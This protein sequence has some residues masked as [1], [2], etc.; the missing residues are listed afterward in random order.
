MKCPTCGHVSGPRRLEYL[1]PEQ[2]KQR[3]AARVLKD[4][5][6][7]SNYPDI[8][9]GLSKDQAWAWAALE[10]LDR[11]SKLYMPK[12]LPWEKGNG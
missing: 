12:R 8:L 5:Q 1:T 6:H 4:N 3:W 11:K 2:R 10:T 9:V 7:I